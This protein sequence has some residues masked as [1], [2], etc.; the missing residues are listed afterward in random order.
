MGYESLLPY[1]R[2]LTVVAAYISTNNYWICVNDTFLGSS[3]S[4]SESKR[5]PVRR[6]GV[7]I[8][9][10]TEYLV[11]SPHAVAPPLSMTRTATFR[12]DLST[13]A[14]TCCILES[15][16]GQQWANVVTTE[17]EVEKREVLRDLATCEGCVA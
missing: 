5:C 4:E 15:L 14:N 8:G 9:A 7:T 6:I 13:G 1:I 17:D 10:G 3:K 11:Q 12:S 2:A 16:S